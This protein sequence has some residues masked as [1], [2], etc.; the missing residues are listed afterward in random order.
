M[1]L[2]EG[3][4]PQLGREDSD[5]ANKVTCQLAKVINR[6]LQHDAPAME[7]EEWEELS[8][9]TET[10][11][12]GFLSEPINSAGLNSESYFPALWTPCDWD[13]S[14][15]QYWHTAMII[16]CLAEPRPSEGSALK[17]IQR[18]QS[19]QNTLDYHATYICALAINSSSTP[20]WINSFGPI[21]FC[22]RWLRERKKA[23]ELI[24]AVRNWGNRTGW[25]VGEVLDCIQ[26]PW[27]QKPEIQGQKD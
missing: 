15:W 9:E 11:V 6:C 8:K 2:K 23:L 7:R 24:D 18:T 16:L 14:S 13:T 17:Q 26:A 21:S 5:F 10:Y 4:V 3:C 27:D 20:V 22:A 12:G 19:F 1:D 25:P